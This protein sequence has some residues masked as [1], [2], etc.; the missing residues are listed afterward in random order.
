MPTVTNS[1]SVYVSSVGPAL[2]PAFYIAES[3]ILVAIYVK[4][5]ARW[6]VSAAVP[7]RESQ[8]QMTGK[9]ASVR[10]HM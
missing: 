8:F 1:M 10:T 4:D 3:V 9:F 5:Q 2:I 7:H 6:S